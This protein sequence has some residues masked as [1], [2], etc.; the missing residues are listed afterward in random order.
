MRQHEQ[1]RHRHVEANGHLAGSEVSLEFDVARLQGPVLVLGVDTPVG[2]GLF[3][4]ILRFRHDVYGSANYKAQDNFEDLAFSRLRIADL[5]SQPSLERLLGEVKPRTVFNCMALDGAGS[6]SLD[7]YDICFNLTQRL[8]TYL[9]PLDIACYLHLAYLRP[10][11]GSV[12]TTAT[13][14]T[15]DAA[16]QDRLFAAPVN[17]YEV[18]VSACSS[19][20]SYYGRTRNLSCALLCLDPLAQAP[21]ATVIHEA[22]TLVR[23][24]YGRTLVA[25]YASLLR[26]GALW[27]TAQPHP[28]GKNSVSAIIACYNEGP[29]IPVMYERLKNTF[30]KLGIDYEIIYVNNGSADNSE[31][32]IRKLSEQDPR[33]IGI[34]HSRSFGAETSFRSGLELASKQACVLLDGDLQDPPEMIEQFVE[35][36]RQGYDVVYGRRVKREAPLFM[37]FSYKLFYRMFSHFAYFKIPQD[38]GDF[39]LMD[40]KVVDH[41]LKF[42][43]RDLWLRGIR[44]YVGFNQTGVD[45]VRPERMFGKTSNNLWKNIGWAKKGILSFTRMPLDVLSNVSVFMVLISAVLGI[46]QVLAKLLFPESTAWGITT[47]LIVVLF[48]GSINLFAV[49]LVGEYIAKIFDE[50]KQRPLFIRRSIIRHGEIRPTSEVFPGKEIY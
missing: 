6:D 45:Y 27:Q 13:G 1:S 10:K 11:D 48:F 20:I 50:V 16:S 42:R 28:T 9:E 37:Q 8:L 21:G 46:L 36:W 49:S 25:D 35:Q 34:T 44:A 33:V 38:A 39:S 17:T 19:L 47:V 2:E 18:A 32:L 3:K 24:D 30:L 5:L 22:A 7:A 43:E 26:I 41:V 15:G 23:K 4:S 12:S 14:G 31:E 40:R 29:A